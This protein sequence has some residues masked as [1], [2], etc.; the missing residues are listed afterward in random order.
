[1]NSCQILLWIFV[2]VGIS[3]LN[4][5]S[6]YWSVKTIDPE[7]YHLSQWL[8]I[9]GAVIRW[10]MIG[11]A[12]GLALSSSITAMLVVFLTFLV[13]RLVLLSIYS[14][15]WQKVQSKMN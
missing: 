7:K 15:K 4:F 2:G 8:I 5:V 14:P 3:I 12:L 9:G 11:I 13:C 1:M 10:A 6:Q